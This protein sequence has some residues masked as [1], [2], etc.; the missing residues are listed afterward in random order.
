MMNT[1]MR[2]RSGFAIMLA[3]LLVSMVPFGAAASEHH[4]ATRTQISFTSTT[5]ETLQPG[6]EWFDEAGIYHLENEIFRDEVSGDISGTATITFN[7]AFQ[8]VGE[9]TEHACPGYFSYWAD[10]EIEG[11]EGGWTGT[12]VAFGSDIPGEEFFSDTLVLRGT[13]A[14]AHDSIVGSSVGEEGE[15]ITFEGVRSTMATPIN[16]LDTSVQL[17]ADPETFAFS[18]GYLSSGALEGHGAASG[19]FLVGGGPWDHTYAVG[20]MVTLSDEHGSLTVAFA[21]DAQDNYTQ[22]F[23]ASHVFGHFVI[24]EGSG[25]YAGLYGSGRI[26]GT[27]GGSMAGC[28]SG[29]GVAISMV[30]EA[31]YN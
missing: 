7:A 22:T 2:R 9:C 23:E 16:G 19:E 24:I 17:C 27:A 8:P 1:F 26:V 4:T 18:G 12:Y 14:N 29:F 5:V 25:D 11:E 10:L 31:H 20:G 3:A 13:G 30:G 15:S 28:A 6:E 21:G